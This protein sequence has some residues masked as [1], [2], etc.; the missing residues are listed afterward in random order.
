[1]KTII[2][3]IH[4]MKKI[5]KYVKDATKHTMSKICKKLTVIITVK[6]VS[7]II[8]HIAI[9]A[10]TL[11]QTTKVIQLKTIILYVNI[12]IAITLPVV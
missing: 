6:N 11:Y 12:V 9:I 3:V 1:M 4:V 10:M 7:M 5:T 2:T 8:L